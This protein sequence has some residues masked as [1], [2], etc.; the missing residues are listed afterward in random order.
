[1]KPENDRA[2]ERETASEHGTVTAS[3][4]D[5]TPDPHNAN[6]GTERGDGMLEHSLRNYGAGRSAL[7]DKNLKLIAGNKTVQKCAELGIP[8]RVVQTTGHELVVVQRTDLDLDEDPAARELAY[9]DN[10]V[11][12]ENLEWDVDVIQADLAA[13]EPVDLSALFSNLE[14]ASLLGSAAPVPKFQPEAPA[15]RLDELAPDT[16]CPACGHQFK[17]EPR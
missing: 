6:R 2:P 3:L 5:L 7:A 11:G 8:I 15:H 13:G 10:R 9:A 16:T 12:Q 17:Q 14:L 1:M 4:T